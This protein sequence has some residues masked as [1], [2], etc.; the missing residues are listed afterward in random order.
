MGRKLNIKTGKVN[1]LIIFLKHLAWI[2][3]HWLTRVISPMAKR[4]EY[5][6]RRTIPRSRKPARIPF[7]YF[8]LMGPGFRQIGK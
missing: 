5:A 7:E 3:F 4:E 2:F 6:P 1:R 8:C